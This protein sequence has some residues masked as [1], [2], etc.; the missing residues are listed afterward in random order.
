MQ[1]DKYIN[2]DN[3]DDIFKK[4]T[5]APTLGDLNKLL[6]TYFPTW[7]MMNYKE[8]SDDYPS[9]TSNWDTLCDQFNAKKQLILLV[10]E[11]KFDKEHS[12]LMVFSDIL[13]RSGF[14][15]RKYHD[16]LPCKVCNKLIPCKELYELLEMKNV[17]IPEFWSDKCT[18]C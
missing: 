10:E 5:Q 3:V 16:F 8:Y 7:I 6:T 2:P 12:L 14:C 9:L 15:I 11:C 13:T 4:I 17:K 1:T 18:L